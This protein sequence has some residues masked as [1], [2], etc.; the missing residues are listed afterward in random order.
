MTFLRGVAGMSHP[1]GVDGACLSDKRV[2]AKN[3]IEPGHQLTGTCAIMGIFEQ[4]FAQIVNDIIDVAIIDIAQPN[5]MPG[6]MGLV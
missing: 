4:D 2:H 1:N 5:E 6:G 3:V